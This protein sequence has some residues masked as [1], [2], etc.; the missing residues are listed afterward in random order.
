MTINSRSA[1]SLCSIGTCVAATLA[2]LASAWTFESTAQATPPVG[3]LAAGL[4][5][6]QDE[7]GTIKGRLVWGGAEVPQPKVIEAVGKASRDPAVCAATTPILDD[8]LVIDPDSKGV[9]HAIAYLVKPS[10]S[11]PEAV[12][13]LTT[14]TPQVELDQKG[15]VYIPRSIAIHKD[16]DVVFKSSDAINHNVHLNAFTNQPFNVLLPANGSLTK[17]FVPEKR[18][19]PLTCDIHA[20]M[21]ANIMV[22]DHPFFAVTAK[23]GSFEIKGVPAGPQ[24]LVIWQESTG[25]V[26]VATGLEVQAE[27]GKVTDLGQVKLDPAKVKK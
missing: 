15:C 24:H 12:K 13:E 20:W 5:T 7:F 18:A 10:G 4:T 27:S 2:V 23:D 16:Q 14:K 3:A 17:R 22:F 9:Q 6:A 11:N 1:S 8:R 26:T 25:Y 19:M 21:K